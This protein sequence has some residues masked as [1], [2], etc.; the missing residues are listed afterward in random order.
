[1]ENWV[2]SFDVAQ[3]GEPVEPFRI[4]GFVLRI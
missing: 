3:D 1:M 2:L 4:S